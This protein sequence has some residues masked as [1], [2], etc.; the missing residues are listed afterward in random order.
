MCFSLHKNVKRTLSKMQIKASRGK[1]IK[2]LI[3][4]I[5][6]ERLM[7]KIKCFEFFFDTK[8]FYFID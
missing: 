5:N 8:M 6:D 1:G 2:S 3:P 7:H 4:F